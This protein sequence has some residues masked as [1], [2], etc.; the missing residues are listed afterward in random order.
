MAISELKPLSSNGTGTFIGSTDTESVATAWK[1]PTPVMAAA[2]AAS[3]VIDALLIP[4]AQR[5]SFSTLGIHWAICKLMRLTNDNCR[6]DRANL[7]FGV[8]EH[9]RQGA[10]V[11]VLA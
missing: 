6:S 1:A 8:I 3:K 4:S 11:T 2:P 10:L 5:V 9:A 7:L